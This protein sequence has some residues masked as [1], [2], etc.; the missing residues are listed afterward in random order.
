MTFLIEKFLLSC[1]SF[2]GS[3]DQFFFAFDIVPYANAHV[4]TSL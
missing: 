1:D 2:D 3:G 4:K